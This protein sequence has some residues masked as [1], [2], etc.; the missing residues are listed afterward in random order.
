MTIVDVPDNHPNLDEGEI[1]VGNPPLNLLPPGVYVFE[2]T[3]R[4]L[5]GCEDSGIL[6]VNVDNIPAPAAPEVSDFCVDDIV[7]L[8]G[9]IPANPAAQVLWTQISGPTLTFLDPITS[10]DPRVTSTQSGHVVLEYSFSTSDDCYLADTVEF[11]ILPCDTGCLTITLVQVNCF[12][13]GSAD[14]SDDYWNFVVTISGGD[15]ASYWVAP[16]VPEAGPYDVEKTIWVGNILASG[17]TYTLTVNDFFNP[18]CTA[19]ITVQVP[20][21]CSDSCTLSIE[22]RVGECNNNGTPYLISDDFYYVDLQVNGVADNECW[23]VKRTNLDGSSEI[24]GTYYGTNPVTL[25]PFLVSDGNWGLWVVLCDMM[26]C[27]RDAF[28]IAPEPCSGC[29]DVTVSNITCFD[30]NTSDPNDDYWTFDILVNGG[31]GT[32]WIAT[33]PVGQSGPYGVVKTILMGHINQYGSSITFSIYDNTTKACRTDVTIPV[34]TACSDSCNLEIRTE[35]TRC[36]DNGT[37]YLISDDF[38]SVILDVSGV[39]PGECWMVKRTN[40]DGT[41]QILGT[42]NSSTSVALGPF[43]ISDGNWNLWVVLC[44]TS[45]YCN[46]DSYII[47]PEP[48]S[49]CHKVTIS[50]VTCY[51]NGT[52]DPSDDHWSF[53][54]LVDGGPGSFWTATAPVGQSGPYGVVKTIYMGAISQYGG[55]IEF[56]IFDDKNKECRTDVSIVVPRACSDECKLNVRTNFSEC[57]RI[58]GQT[59]YYVYLTV[60][61]SNGNCWTVKRKLS[62][63]TEIMLG[64]WSG[65]QS[66]ILGPFN[67]SEGDWTIW[68]MACGQFDCVRDLY[69]RM[70]CRDADGGT[71]RSEKAA[72]QQAAAF[73]LFPSPVLDA[74]NIQRKASADSPMAGEAQFIVLDMLG[75][76]VLQRS[77]PVAKDYRLL[78]NELSPGLYYL[79]VKEQ[80]SVNWTAKFIKR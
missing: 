43:L 28:I 24:L 49:G 63:G 33:A 70:P 66:I 35:V 10:T 65:D 6:T 37:P 71:E 75:K 29:H 48:C 78:V 41:S 72:V 68:V 58:E 25:G 42:Y 12:D 77:M 17:S 3:A 79:V 55:T 69:I 31:P 26:T 7:Q 45:R 19:T 62:N 52:S 11:D 46:A 5:T 80:D 16:A 59:V 73:N 2:V 40:P 8:V 44:D 20:E 50:N 39:A 23:M 57:Q 30:N 21:P 53:D 38:Y 27:N 47:A 51:D 15:P 18:E 61:G 34:P 4:R 60:T 9:S 22:T 64:T 32:Y 36:D 56:S 54:I 1:L 74:L 67:A 14:P 13:N 76:T